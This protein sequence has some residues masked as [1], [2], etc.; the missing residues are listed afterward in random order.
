MATEIKTK[1]ELTEFI[2]NDSK[3]VV[4]KLGA[5]WCAPCTAM[6][7]AVIEFITETADW[8]VWGDIDVDAMEEGGYED[9]QEDYEVE[10]LP[11]FMIFKGGEKVGTYMGSKVGGNGDNGM[12]DKVNEFKP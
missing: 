11:Y 1:E 5:Q 10:G 6:K 3:V 7:P 9:F 8:A 12:K 4:L 2:K